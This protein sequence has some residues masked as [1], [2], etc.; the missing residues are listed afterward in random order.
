[1]SIRS[2]IIQKSLNFFMR[3]G[4]KSVSM[5][6]I[7]RELGMSKKTL[8]Q[9]VKDKKELVYLTFKHHLN[10]DEAFCEAMME[11]TD[12]AIQQLLD[13]GKHLVDH[14]QQMNPSTMFDVQKYYPSCWKL[15]HRHKNEYILNHVQTNITM[16]KQEGLY[17]EELNTEIIS[18]LYIHMVD[19]S[20]NPDIFPEK[21][22]N[23]I[24]IFMQMFD[25]HLHALMT[26]KGRAYFETHKETLFTT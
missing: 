15:F 21:E 25:Y 10:K 13:L 19:A 8:Y 7:A 4:I 23:Q 26:E 24:E 18:R 6:D 14:F 20:V 17:R 22:F 5:D 16:G 3:Y 12:N 1:M 9:H 11:S 2:Q